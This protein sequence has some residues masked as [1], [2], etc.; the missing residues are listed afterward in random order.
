[1]GGYKME[2]NGL[3]ELKAWIKKHKSELAGAS[4]E[5]IVNLAIAYGFNR[6]AVAEWQCSVMS[7][8]VTR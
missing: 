2:G 8:V 1:M 6:T 3:A 5:D 4:T 7:K